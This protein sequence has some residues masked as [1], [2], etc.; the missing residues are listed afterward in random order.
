MTQRAADEFRKSPSGDRKRELIG[1]LF[2]KLTLDGERLQP[3][4]NP[5]A[6]WLMTEILPV[7]G[8]GNDKFGRG[9]SGSTESKKAPNG[10]PR[11][12]WRAVAN[13][14]RTLFDQ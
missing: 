12:S 5:R 4:Y 13:T 9:D 14:I 6:A 1:E 3:Q 10:A 2:D 8:S 7:A 11:Y